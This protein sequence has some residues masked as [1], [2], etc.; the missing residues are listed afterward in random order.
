VVVAA[1]CSSRQTVKFIAH[2]VE[3]FPELVMPTP[4]GHDSRWKLLCL[5]ESLVFV[6][7]KV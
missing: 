7:H 6:Y 1:E 4:I 5:L 2:G 3:D